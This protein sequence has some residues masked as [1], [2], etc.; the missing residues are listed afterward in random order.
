MTIST[1]INHEILQEISRS[2]RFS[3]VVRRISIRACGEGNGAHL[4]EI[5]GR[6]YNSGICHI[7]QHPTVDALVKAI[8]VLRLRAFAWYGCHPRPPQRIVEA[9]LESSRSSLS[10]LLLP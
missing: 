9:L 3:C 7:D 1:S 8:L 10:E 6:W 5:E 4:A 2:P